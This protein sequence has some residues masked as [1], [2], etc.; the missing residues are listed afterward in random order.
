MAAGRRPRTASSAAGDSRIPS[1]FALT[2]WLKILAIGVLAWLILERV[3]GYLTHITFA[4]TIAVGG[5]FIAYIVYPLIRKLNERVPLWAAVVAVYGSFA[6]LAFLALSYVVPLIA[7]QFQNLV[8]ALPDF[9]ERTRAALERPDLPIIS[10]LPVG[11]LHYVQQLPVQLGSLV[12]GAA[13]NWG[14]VFDVVLSLLSLAAILLIMPIVSI[15]MLNEAE[16]IKGTF[17]GMLPGR[18]RE[19][20]K[21]VLS[22]LDAVFGGFVRGQLIVALSVGLLVTLLLLVLRV[23][24]ALLIGSWAALL[25]VVP[26]LGALAGAIP[27]VLVALFANGVESAVL[28]TV[29]FFVIYQI[30]GSLISPAVSSRMVRVSPLTTIFALVVGGELFGI[31][32]ILLAVP[33]AGAIRVIIDNVRPPDHLTVGEVEPGLTRIAQQDVHQHA[34]DSNVSKDD[35]EREIAFLKGD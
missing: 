11:V 5:L 21:N 24:Y 23:P 31:L 33:A 9:E 12:H 14:G 1:D 4:V 3:A 17:L 18:H 15:Y 7:D 35:V 29:G 32:G 28:A 19:H 13:T 25:E 26:Y 27:G 30:D 22:Q 20:A 34:A 16:G 10:R 6:I 2:R 8:A